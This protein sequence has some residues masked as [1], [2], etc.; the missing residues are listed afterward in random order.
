MCS[1]ITW[2]AGVG[3]DGREVRKGGDVCIL[4]ADSCYYT[5]ETNTS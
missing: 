3:V 5:A 1:V 4:I 2:R